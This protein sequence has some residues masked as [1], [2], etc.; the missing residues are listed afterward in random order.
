MSVATLE[1]RIARLE[2]LVS[3]LEARTV[4][5]VTLGPQ[6]ENEDD[7]ARRESKTRRLID[8]VKKKLSPPP[9]VP[10]VDRS[11]QVLTD[12]SPVPEDRSHTQDRG[13]GQQKDYV[14]LS[15]NERKKGFVRPVRDSYIHVGV[16]GHEV[17]PSNPAK[18]GLKA[19]GCG[20]LTRMG[21]ILAETY[22]RDPKFYNGTFCVGCGK[23]FPLDQFVWADTDEI[24][25]S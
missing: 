24:V 13:D 12:G 2:R 1:D 15:A 21:L 5:L 19:P 3:E 16:G 23:H 20:V 8:A 9:I 10:P 11:Q 7:V 4:G 18:S 14:V 25:G 22:A 6:P 17:D